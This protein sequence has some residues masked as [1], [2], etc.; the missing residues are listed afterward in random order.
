MRVTLLRKPARPRGSRRRIRQIHQ[1]GARRPRHPCA[2]ARPACSTQ[3]EQ[4]AGAD[5]RPLRPCSRR[6]RRS[7]S[8]T[9]S[10]RA[11]SS[12]PSRGIGSTRR[13]SRWRCGTRGRG[14]IRAPPGGL[15][16]S[17]RGTAQ[18]RDLRRDVVLDVT[19]AAA[20][21]RRRRGLRDAPSHGRARP[22]RSRASRRSSTAT[23]SSPIPP[24]PGGAHRLDRE[25]L[26]IW[27]RGGY[28]LIALPNPDGSFTATLFLPMH[29]A[30]SELCEPQGCA[31]AIEEFLRR[32][33]SRRPRADARLRR[34]I[35]RQPD[36]ISRHRVRRRAGTMRRQRP[37]WSATPRTRS[38]PF[39]ARA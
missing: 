7:C 37:L 12:T 28:M 3:I 8:P 16:I 39:T 38:C 18:I 34:R 27:P 4:L 5:A 31:A 19:H 29:G 21:R 32:E 9:G 26:H 15:R 36:R 14:E 11:K 30:A 10:G 6:R 13:C 2:R 33:L 23:R 25:A 22:D 24:G 1:S 20:D 17:R 35:R